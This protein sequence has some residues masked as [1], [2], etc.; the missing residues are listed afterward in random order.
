MTIVTLAHAHHIIAK[1]YGPQFDYRILSKTVTIGVPPIERTQQGAPTLAWNRVRPGRDSEIRIG[2]LR[3]SHSIDWEWHPTP[4]APPAFQLANVKALDTNSSNRGSLH[5]V[6]YQYLRT[7][8]GRPNGRI[9]DDKVT[10]SWVIA[11]TDGTVASIYDYKDTNRF[12]PELPTVPE[13]RLMNRTWELGGTRH[14][15]WHVGRVLDLLFQ[16]K[17]RLTAAIPAC[18]P[19]SKYLCIP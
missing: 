17:C 8:F 19:V 15:L 3:D 13:M 6:S 7:V 12:S 18:C 14:A 16:R 5:G 2:C 1:H 10:T 9:A 4:S 11:F